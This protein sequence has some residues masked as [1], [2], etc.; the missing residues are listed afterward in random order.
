L[1]AVALVQQA[2]DSHLAILDAL[3]LHFRRVRREHGTDEGIVKEA[4]QRIG[5]ARFQ[6]IADG[7]G[8][9]ALARR[10]A[11]DQV[12][13]RA[14]DVVL[15]FCN[16]GQQREIAEGARQLRRFFLR[17]RLQR[18][19]QLRARHLV[20]VAAETD[21]QLAH[22]FDALEGGVAQVVRMASPSRRPSWRI[23]LLSSSSFTSFICMVCI[24]WGG[25]GGTARIA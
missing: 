9:A 15:I 11:G 16:V 14:A 22:V 3:A 25:H 7:V 17:Q 12:G 23:S 18:V 20:I 6:H 1:H 10:R 21:G 5:L 13:A 2:R 24:S 8:E 19:R 4:F